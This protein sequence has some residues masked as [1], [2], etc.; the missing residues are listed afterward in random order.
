MASPTRHCNFTFF[1]KSMKKLFI[2][3]A[4][5]V[6]LASCSDEQDPFEWNKDRIGMLTKESKVYQLDSLFVNDSIVRPGLNGELSGGAD[7]IEVYEKG[8]KHLLTLTPYSADTTATIENVR[9]RDE[10][11]TTAKGININSEFKSINDSYKIGSIDNMIN[12]A[13]I[14]VNEEN[15]YFT[16]KKDVL[17]ADLKFDITAPIDKT[18]IPD[19]AKPE[20]V[21]ISW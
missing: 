5:I 20:F 9:V 16:I 14:W 2:A 15:F 4:V 3:V 8:G 1:K 10:R 11:F 19:T 6:V 13:V 7:A 12:S 17:P 21:F 18:M